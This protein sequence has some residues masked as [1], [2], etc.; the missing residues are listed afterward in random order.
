MK[1]RKVIIATDSFKGSASSVEVANY[2]E[3]GIKKIN[4]NLVIKKI[5]IADGG[6][7]TVEI[8]IEGN[9]KG[10][11]KYLEV[12]GPL[13]LATTARYGVINQRIAIMEMAEASGIQLIKKEDL[14]PFITTTY[15]VGEII[16]EILNTGI[17]EIYI[18]IGGSSTNDGGAGMLAC[19]GA[20][21][22][23]SKG[24]E[25]GYT[26]NDLKFISK[27]DLTNFDK[28]IKET[29]IIVLSD[30]NNVLCGKNG[31]SYVYGPQ[32]GADKK[33]VI[34]L[35][36]ILK[37]YGDLIDKMYNKKYS[38]EPGSG[39][40]GGLGFALLSI[41]GAEIKPGVETIM[42]LI[43]FESEI[44][45]AD[46]VITGE[47]RIDNQSINGKVPIGVTRIAK[48]YN[49][50]VIAVV[51]SSDKNLMNIYKNGVDLVLDIINEPMHLED[52]ILNVK[53]L[54]EFTGEKVA[55]I[56]NLM[57]NKKNI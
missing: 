24:E 29:K 18:G 52:A 41:C 31:A 47:G 45:N 34:E 26:P 11:Y 9:E 15:G 38:L 17:R 2:I 22:Y 16:K 3:N 20:K 23:D 36:S 50:P 44:K 4:K 48:K 14:N 37:R 8:L 5:P 56:L 40:A 46:L 27:I 49:I 42:E 39:A 10:I 32:K 53:E 57:E 19:L 43:D 55:K 54:L 33:E 7:G 35:D 21:F 1:K 25:I 6:E 51:G 13:K 30:V 12:S 28:R